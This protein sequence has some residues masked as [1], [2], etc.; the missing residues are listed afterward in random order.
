M[1][2]SAGRIGWR[3]T[4]HDWTGTRQVNT[5]PSR[6]SIHLAILYRIPH[7][8]ALLPLGSTY[9]ETLHLPYLRSRCISW[10]CFPRRLA[11]NTLI[12]RIQLLRP[13]CRLRTY[14]PQA[15]AMSSI[16]QPIGAEEVNCGSGG[17]ADTYLGLRVA[18]IFVIMA[19]SSFGALFPVLARRTRFLNVPTGL[20]E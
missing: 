5:I 3:R 7:P 9:P 8:L 15:S 16:D 4:Q 11:H 10:S 1:T 6:F 2:P 19:G 12:G 18:S 13:F 20:F 14:T 17:G